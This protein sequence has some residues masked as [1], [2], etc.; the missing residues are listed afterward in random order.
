[1]KRT[2]FLFMIV[3]VLF[4]G[5]GQGP[6]TEGKGGFTGAAGEIKLI[7]LDPGHFHAALVQKSMYHQIDPKVHVYAPAGDDL[8]AHLSR[9]RGFNERS[10][11]ATSWEEIVYTGEDFLER[12]L[13]EKQGNLVI[14]AGNNSLKSD[15]ILKSVEAGLNVMAD[16]PMV[17]T[18]EHYPLLEEAFRVAAEKGVM[19]YDIM[20]ERY[21]ITTI[22][23]RELSMIK[24]V[25][26]DLLPGSPGDPAVTKE[27]VHHF[28]KVVSGVPLQRPAWYFDVD[29]QGEGIVDVTTHLVDL[30]QWEAFP[31]EILKKE[32]VIL[33]SARRWPTGLTLEQFSGVTGMEEFPPFLKSSVEDGVL[34][35]FSNGEFT[36]SLKGVYARVSVIWNY[37]A[38]AGA[39][40][41]HYS[42]MRGS[43][44]NLI[45]RQGPEEGYHP[46][47]YVE[48]AAG[49]DQEIFGSDLAKAVNEKIAASFPGVGVIP[50]GVNRWALEI[51]VAY[52]NGHEAH[53]GQVMEKYLRYLV[54]GKMPE[55]EVPN[56]LVKYYTTTEALRMAY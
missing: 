35:V 52:N 46:V 41:T 36:Y 47:L 15:F 32:D 30:V 25:F 6:A 28:S 27:S 21:E 12:M 5:C 50:A 33:V 11:D 53:F 48:A 23:Q 49:V 19:L 26:G 29:Q 8:S 56:M 55:W 13:A 38:P 34:K 10:D 4:A 39:G 31:E 9:I 45:I 37:S 1:M 20:T 14:I 3:I 40:D 17:I 24:E 42:I 51:P 7:T 16:K 44:C 54:S 43:R 22:L 2:A 18:P